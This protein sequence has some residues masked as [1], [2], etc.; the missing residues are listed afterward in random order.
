MAED[1]LIRELIGWD[2]AGLLVTGEPPS[3][4][5]LVS[6]ETPHPTET[7]ALEPLQEVVAEPEYWPTEVVGYRKEVVPEVMTPYSKQVSL[8]DLSRGTKGIELMGADD[9][10]EQIDI[11][12]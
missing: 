12:G 7:I 5:V 6:G 2:K 3:P 4:S 11:P 9:Q 10:T 1:G 8:D